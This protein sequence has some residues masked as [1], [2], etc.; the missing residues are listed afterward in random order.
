[1]RGNRTKKGRSRLEDLF[2]AKP[3]TPGPVPGVA[4]VNFDLRV[5]L[6]AVTLFGQDAERVLKHLDIADAQWIDQ[7]R[8]VALTAKLMTEYDVLT[9]AGWRVVQAL[10]A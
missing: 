9:P 10:S 7:H 8:S 4:Y 3:G 6:L 1:M 2:D 5:W